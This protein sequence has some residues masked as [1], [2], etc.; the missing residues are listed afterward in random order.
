[1]KDDNLQ[2]K[3]IHL[4][5]DVDWNKYVLD[6][7]AKDYKWVLYYKEMFET[8]NGKRI[9]MSDKTNTYEE[10]EDWVKKHKKVREVKYIQVGCMFLDIAMIILLCINLKFDSD[11][12]RGLTIGSIWTIMFINLCMAFAFSHNMKVDKIEFEEMRKIFESNLDD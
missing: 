4:S 12:L 1:M 8:D 5:L 10:L 2:S 9:I 11:L 3:V 7:F 6:V